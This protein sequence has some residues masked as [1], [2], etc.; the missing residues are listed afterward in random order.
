MK[1]CSCLDHNGSMR[2]G[3]TWLS[4]AGPVGVCLY[5]SNESPQPQLRAGAHWS[6]A[7]TIALTKATFGL[8]SALLWSFPIP[9]AGLHCIQFFILKRSILYATRRSLV[10][11]MLCRHATKFSTRVGGSYMSLSSGVHTDCTP[12]V[13]QGEKHI[14]ELYSKPERPTC[15]QHLVALC[16]YHR[17]PN[18]APPP[19]AEHAGQE[20]H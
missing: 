15:R 17:D 7:I 5:I 4:S 3:W 8:L 12:E 16:A 18:T 19:W 14:L 9:L 2:W 10:T 20:S 11:I 1:S 6:P 13:S